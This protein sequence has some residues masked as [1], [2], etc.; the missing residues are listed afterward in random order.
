MT[1]SS[2]QPVSRRRVLKVGLGW[3]LGWGLAA[4]LAAG[5]GA[6]ELVLHDV[7][8]GRA[9][10]DR[11]DGTCSVPVTRT[12]GQPPGP[13]TSGTFA[14]RARGRQVGYPIAYPPGH[15]P[16]AALPL[17]VALHGY[18]GDHTHP[19]AV[20]TL[21]EA[22]AL[23]V[24]GAPL[25][26]MAMVAADGGG[27]YWHGHPGDNPMAMLVD[28]LIPTCQA[29]GLGRAP[30]RIGVLGISMGGYG[31]VLLAEQHPGLV[32][33]VVAISPAVW[34]TYQQAR[35][36]NPGAFASA[37]DF[38]GND[39]I[40]GARALSG[41]PVRIASGR[42]DP[43]R[44]GVAALVA[45]LPPGAE[46]VLTRGCHTDSFE[47]SQQPASLAFLAHNIA[48]MSPTHLPGTA[49]IVPSNPWTSVP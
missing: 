8:P 39:V 44:P 6:V 18:G 2:G 42:D 49:T 9:A 32:S 48:G 23:Q 30:Q 10:L 38:A 7:L 14:S 17:I 31:A 15:G 28:E 37:A 47:A 40:A 36:A 3:G 25:A 27:G 24:D 41:T 35:T 45:A 11:L 43:F 29:L 13:V 1:G 4:L 20:L 21:V 33:A 26:P 12:T 16:G 5:G 19:L 22:L 46:V 34:T